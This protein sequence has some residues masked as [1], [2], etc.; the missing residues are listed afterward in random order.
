MYITVIDIL[1]KDPVQQLLNI[2][3]HTI[4]LEDISD[5]GVSIK[6]NCNS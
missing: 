3:I 4:G 5:V 6:K 2:N 1:F